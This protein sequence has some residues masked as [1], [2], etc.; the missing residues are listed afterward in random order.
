MGKG[1]NRPSALDEARGR[2]RGL[3]GPAGFTFVEVM[4][5]GLL[6]V[7]LGAVTIPLY[8]GYV[9]KQR[10]EAVKNMAQAAS[11]AANSYWRRH[12]VAPDSAAL[13]LFLP[14]ANVFGISIDGDSVLVED[15]DY[16]STIFVKVGYK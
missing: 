8:T 4:V 5:V 11:V 16:P 14:Q 9:E 12:G 13:G 3:P 6:V 7:I 1:S 2:A 10:R 15:A